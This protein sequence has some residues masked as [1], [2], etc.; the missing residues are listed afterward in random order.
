[1]CWGEGKARADKRA[2]TSDRQEVILTFSYIFIF[3]CFKMYF[4]D[5]ELTYNVC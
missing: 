3:C 5:I 1:M 4:I 2:G